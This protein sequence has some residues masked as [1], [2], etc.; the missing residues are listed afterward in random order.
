MAEASSRWGVFWAIAAIVGG[1]GVLI[2]LEIMEE[3]NMTLGQILMELV[4]P[5]L[6][7][8]A[9]AGVVYLMQRTKQQHEEQLS[10]LRDLETARAEG[11]QWRSDMREVVKGLGAAI[12]AQFDR[13]GLTPPSARWRCSC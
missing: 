3:P 11:A 5:S 6:T 12:D 2:W 9:A 8:L 10:L 4:E 1:V 7:V 13:W